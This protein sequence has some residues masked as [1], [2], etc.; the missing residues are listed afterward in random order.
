MNIESMTNA[1]LK[2][3]LH[4]YIDLA[5]EKKLKA[6]YVMVEDDLERFENNWEDENFV[7][8]I[9][10]RSAAIKNGGAKTYTWEEVQQRASE[11]LQMLR[12]Q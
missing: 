8:E 12:K 9:E 2:K 5:D 10:K 6:I 3:K 4:E 11:A 7:A 1:I